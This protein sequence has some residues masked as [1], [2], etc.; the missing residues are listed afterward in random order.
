VVVVVVVVVV[1]CIVDKREIVFEKNTL[2][3]D[4]GYWFHRSR[5]TF[6]TYICQFQSGK[7][8]FLSS[9]TQF[10]GKPL[11]KIGRRQREGREGSSSSSSSSDR[12]SVSS[13]SSFSS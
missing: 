7:A 8:F 6:E 11:L 2:W 3:E 9:P 10:S 1:V 13:S 12:F 4:I 5:H